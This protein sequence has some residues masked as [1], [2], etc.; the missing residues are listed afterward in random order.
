MNKVIMKYNPAFL[1]PDELVA[2][3][4]VRHGELETIMQIIKE[5]VMKSNQ[6]ILVVGPRGIGKTMLLLRAVEEIRRN[7]D[8]SQKWY[9]LVFS[10]ESYQVSTCGEF[11]LEA[12]LHLAR[13]TKNERW[14]KL[15]EDLREEKDEKRLR[16]ECLHNLW[17]LQMSKRN[18]FFSS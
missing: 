14:Q 5:N 7:R 9:P 10:E 13:Q 1:S 4:V 8:L 3:F 16:E 17:I 15:F 12:L 6:H 18:E 2:S 11:W